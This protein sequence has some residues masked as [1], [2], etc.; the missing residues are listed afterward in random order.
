MVDLKLNF[1]I[2]SIWRHSGATSS[3]EQKLTT[4][5]MPFI[6]TIIMVKVTN[7][8][9][10]KKA[11]L[12]STILLTSNCVS[13]IVINLINPFGRIITTTDYQNGIFRDVTLTILVFIPISILIAVAFKKKVPSTEEIQ[14][15]VIDKN[16]NFN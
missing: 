16:E 11:A 8:L 12:L 2:L 6:L 7:G 4:I 5:C 13:L 9:N 10:R 1:I 15:K 3:I 14:D